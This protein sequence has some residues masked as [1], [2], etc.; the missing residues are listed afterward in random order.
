M[1]IDE[2]SISGVIAVFEAIFKE[3]EI[4]IN[5]EGFVR[6]IIIVSGDLKSGL[7]LD[8]AQNTRIGQEELKNSFG[9]LEYILGLFHTKMVAVVSVL[10]THLGDPKAGQDAPASLFLHNSILERKPFVATSLPPF[11]VAKDLIMDLLGARIIHCLFEI[12][13]VVP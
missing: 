4:D 10:S 2:S 6:D 13:I 11:A 12:P 5:A 1:D 8:G 7:N 3:L 9:N